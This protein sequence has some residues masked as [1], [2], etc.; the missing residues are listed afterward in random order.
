[1]V[2]IKLLEES[3]T[4]PPDIPASGRGE[5]RTGYYSLF[6]TAKRYRVRASE[7][8]FQNDADAITV[9]ALHSTSSHKEMWEPTLEALLQVLEERNDSARVKI[10]EVWAVDCP[11]HGHAGVLNREVLERQLLTP[12][13]EYFCTDI[14][15]WFGWWGWHPSDKAVNTMR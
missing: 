11:N 12:N 6:I 1:M 14:D 2:A 4:L 10:R 8:A 9:L 13:C 7:K 5:W 3:F 15:N